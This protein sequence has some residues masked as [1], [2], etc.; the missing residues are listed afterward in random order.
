MTQWNHFIAPYMKS[1]VMA[2]V[3]V[4]GPLMQCMVALFTGESPVLSCVGW[5]AVCSD[6]VAIKFH[7]AV[8]M[9]SLWLG[10]TS[11]RS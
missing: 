9:E 6:V 7:I 5:G 8:V 2:G 11:E 1:T 4:G 10:L 3:E